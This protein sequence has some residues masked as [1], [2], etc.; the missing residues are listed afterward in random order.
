[1]K[2]IVFTIQYIHK[3]PNNEI[4]RNKKNLPTNICGWHKHP[5]KESEQNKRNYK[6]SRRMGRPKRDEN[7]QEQIK[8]YDIK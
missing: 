2:Y 8:N 7:K 5:R 1:M 4:H 6:N 3:W